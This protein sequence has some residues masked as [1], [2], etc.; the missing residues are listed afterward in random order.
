MYT[1]LTQ[2][3]NHMFVK[4]LTGWKIKKQ[5]TLQRL[6]RGWDSICEGPEI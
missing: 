2:I 1:A 6:S 5:S 3:V 4:A